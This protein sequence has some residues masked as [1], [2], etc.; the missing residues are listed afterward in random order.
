MGELFQRQRAR[1]VR[2]L[3]GAIGL[4][5]SQCATPQPRHS[6]DHLRRNALA[7]LISLNQVFGQREIVLSE[8][9]ANVSDDILRDCRHRQKRYQNYS[10]SH[11]K[12]L[13][14]RARNGCWLPDPRA[15]APRPLPST[16]AVAAQRAAAPYRPEPEIARIPKPVFSGTAPRIS[17][18]RKRT[19]AAA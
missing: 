5:R 6:F 12:C 11:I 8:S 7:L 17:D 3:A 16:R 10:Q 1:A 14:H 18:R 15:R 4:P 9:D 19:A 13:T 2:I